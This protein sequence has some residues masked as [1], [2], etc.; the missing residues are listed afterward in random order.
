M[1]S[2]SMYVFPPV[3]LVVSGIS[4]YKFLTNIPQAPQPGYKN[5]DDFH[6]PYLFRDNLPKESFELVFISA[7]FPVLIYKEHHP[8]RGSDPMECSRLLQ[9]LSQGP[10]GQCP[11]PEG[12]SLS[13]SLSGTVPPELP[14][15]PASLWTLSSALWP[16]SEA[17]GQLGRRR[18]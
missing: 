5:Q 14:H 12:P 9:Q 6:K 13:S 7:F 3:T 16:T 11:T 18:L 15:L 4:D 10:Q 1:L 2:H 8:S 17:G